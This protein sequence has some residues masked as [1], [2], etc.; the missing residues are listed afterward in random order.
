MTCPSGRVIVSL[1]FGVSRRS[2]PSWCTCW[3][4]SSH[5]GSKLSGRSGRRVATRRRDAA[6]F[7]RTGRSSRGSRTWCTS[8]GL[9]AVGPCSAAATYDLVATGRRQSITTP[10][11]TTTVNVFA[12]ERTS[13]STRSGSST[14]S[15]QSI[16]GVPS[17]PG[18]VS[19][20]TTITSGLPGRPPW[21]SN[22]ANNARALR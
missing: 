20:M 12:R 22:T 1:R 2:Q 18:W 7:W 11:R 19:S 15:P 3:W 5:K 13:A 21:P 6:W 14:G 17:G 4:C 8:R 16:A 9:P 10:L